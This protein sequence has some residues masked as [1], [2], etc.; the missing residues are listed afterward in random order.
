[1]MDLP[2]PGAV[3]VIGYG[4][5][6]RRD[7]GV[8]PWVARELAAL[9]LPQVR[10]R[11]LHQLV[12]ELAAELAE[13]QLAVFIDARVGPSRKR[14]TMA[15]LV[16]SANPQVFGHWADPG[17]LLTLASAYGQ[18]PAAVLVSVTGQDF[19]LGEGLSGVAAANARRALRLAQN[20]IYSSLR[21]ADRRQEAKAKGPCESA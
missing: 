11:T 1:M 2:E 21:P 14:V 4:N 15:R 10:V 12:P 17:A 16:P 8:G 5:E 20:L 7:D 13:A 19:G 3:L 6:L 18:A 9:G